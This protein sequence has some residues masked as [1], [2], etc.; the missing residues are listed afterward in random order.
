M[1]NS[2]AKPCDQLSSDRNGGAKRHWY[3]I[4]MMVA[5]IGALSAMPMRASAAVITVNTLA[6]P[7]GAT[8]TC[9]LRQAITN[10]NDDSQTYGGCAA[11]SG[12]DSIVFSVSGTIALGAILPAIS[13][14][15]TI[16]GPASGITISG[17]N[18]VQIM[19]VSSGGV[20]TLSHLTISNAA[21]G[22][23]GAIYNAGVL[24]VSDSVLSNNVVNGYSGGYSG[25]GGAIFNDGGTVTISNTTLSGNSAVTNGGAIDND[26]G[27]LTV[28][29]STLSGNSAGDSGG[30]IANKYGTL[31]LTNSTLV[32][33]QAT[34]LGGA[35]YSYAFTPAAITNATFSGNSAG[36]SGGAIYN[37]GMLELHGTIL[38]ASSGGNCSGTIINAGYNISDDAS[39]NLGTVTGASGLAIGDNVD[40]GLDPAGLADNGG[41]TQ[42][43]AL[44]A[45]SPAIDAIPLA[46][47]T[48]QATPPNPLITD[49]RGV[50]RPDAED[51]QSPAC[52][53]G[54][55]E[56]TAAADP[57]VAPVCSGASASTPTIYPPNGQ[58]VAE[59]VV[60]V[61]DSGG[62]FT[63]LITAVNQD[64]PISQ[65]LFPDATGVGTAG[66]QVRA[67]RD[68]DGTGRIYTLDFTA[69]DNQS[70]GQCSGQVTVCVPHDRRHG[71]ACV[72]TGVLFDATISN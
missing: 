29:G 4:L 13:G 58:M 20:V 71:S 46:S 5:I 69:T 32:G 49:Q 72:A 66:A 23:F 19:S 57:V 50:S 16:T 67:E 54:A 15:V 45:S 60:G 25:T 2:T 53:I 26:A 39:C 6:D 18:T 48:D 10:A 44:L 47:C 30:A 14:A 52:D 28:T 56:Y 70:G 65:Y 33:N 51:S 7:A 62:P 17:N 9:S 41:S 12:A 64:E 8:G 37:G 40:P 24:T 38:A 35:I 61:T 63:I 11:G 43:I 42:T 34:D 3:S 31:T 22:G 1:S 27:T 55:Y 21:S 36:T 59:S 68:G